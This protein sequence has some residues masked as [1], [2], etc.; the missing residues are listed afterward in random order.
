M[1][2]ASTHG[3]TSLVLDNLSLPVM[4]E[5]REVEACIFSPEDN[6][7]EDILHTIWYGFQEVDSCALYLVMAL[8]GWYFNM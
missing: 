8:F 6:M 7:Q 2:T 5:I 1:E 4:K 3:S